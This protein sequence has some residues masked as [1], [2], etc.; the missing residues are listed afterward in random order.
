MKK[1]LLAAA[2]LIALVAGDPATAADMRVRAAPPPPVAPV[3]SWTGLY[4]GAGWGYG[5][6]NLDTTVN[7]V[8]L[9][10][11]ASQ[12]LGG[13][14][15]LGIVTVGGDY[16]LNN[17]LLVGGFAD[18]DLANIKSH[19]QISSP[20]VPF[21]NVRESNAW[22]VGARAGLLLNPQFLTYFSGGYT[23]ARFTDDS[24]VFPSHN[25]GG[26]FIGSGVETRL[27]GLFG[28]LGPGWFWRNE[29]RFA[30]YRS[31]AFTTS[32]ALFTVTTRPFVQTFRTE[33]IYKF[34]WG[35]GY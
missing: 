11:S 26:W 15:W 29:Y 8:G 24:P 30:D 19:N 2:A 27:G 20:L 6:Y 12:T 23:R 7:V 9:P 3:S 5:M 18:Y 32:P 13:R 4:V 17:W 28:I 25:Y 35:G 22:A 10:A 14:G 33:V 34:N 31:S 1:L 16:Q 21:G